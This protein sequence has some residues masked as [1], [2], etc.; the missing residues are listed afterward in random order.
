VVAVS[1]DVAGIDVLL[2]GHTHNQM[3]RPAVVNGATIIQSGY[4]ASFVGRLDIE[5]DGTKVGGIRH[6]LITLGD[7][8]A[9]DAEMQAII[10]RMY[11]VTCLNN[12]L[13]CGSKEHTIVL[14]YRTAANGRSTIH[15]R[16]R[17]FR[18]A[19]GSASRDCVNSV[20]DEM[21]APHKEM[22]AE[23]VGE[24]ETVL[25]CY[26]TLKATMDNVL[27][28]AVADA[29]GVDDYNLNH[30]ATN[31]HVSAEGGLP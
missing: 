30:E 22:L 31:V 16:K 20:I 25:N 13:A 2:S 21:Y 15:S 1:D 29:A 7:S 23:I 4:H 27:L 24:T 6:R 14:V 10:D 28:D 19:A 3:I 18:A 8:I 26:T 9:P 17:Y 5:M 12:L 11:T